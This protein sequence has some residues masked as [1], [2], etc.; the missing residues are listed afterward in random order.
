MVMLLQ[1]LFL[2]LVSARAYAEAEEQYFLA[3]PVTR[4][5]YEQPDWEHR[6]A[7]REGLARGVARFDDIY[8][9]PYKPAGPVDID[10]VTSNYIGVV[11]VIFGFEKDGTEFESVTRGRDLNIRYVWTHDTHKTPGTKF[12]H[13]HKL[14]LHSDRKAWFAGE[15]LRLSNRFKKDGVYTLTAMLR[16]EELFASQFRLVGCEN[17][18]TLKKRWGDFK[19][20]WSELQERG[21][22]PG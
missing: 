19:E 2:L 21:H 14:E 5:A 20:S 9:H 12:D 15:T 17:V 7:F 16:G 3:Y 11:F 8:L 1:V 6:R 10:C 18:R 22:E 4:Y 13:H